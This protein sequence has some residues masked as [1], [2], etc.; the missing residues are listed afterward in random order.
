[1]LEVQIV[2]IIVTSSHISYDCIQNLHYLSSVIIISIKIDIYRWISR[3]QSW[4]NN[5]KCYPITMRI[6][7]FFKASKKV[8]KDG[9]TGRIKKMMLKIILM[10]V[11][12]WKKCMWRSKGYLPMEKIWNL[13]KRLKSTSICFK[14]QEII[15]IVFWSKNTWKNYWEVKYTS[16]SKQVGNITTISNK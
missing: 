8:W 12:L 14:A 16:S 4:Y 10:L 7:L 1:M 13:K 9:S 6:N 5:S 11:K 2:Y 3:K 15:N